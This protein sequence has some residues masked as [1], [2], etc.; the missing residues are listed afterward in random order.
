M[1]FIGFTHGVIDARFFVGQRAIASM[2][3]FVG[4]DWV[5]GVGFGADV[6]ALYLVAT[7]VDN[8]WLVVGVLTLEL[9]QIG[10]AC[11]LCTK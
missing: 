11:A 9:A 3:V 7:Y 6:V 10:G 2:A 5:C 1:V 8:H 4:I